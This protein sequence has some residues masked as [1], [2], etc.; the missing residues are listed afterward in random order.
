MEAAGVTIAICA[1]KMIKAAIAMLLMGIVADRLKVMDKRMIP[2]TALFKMLVVIIAIAMMTMLKTIA[3]RP[4][5]IGPSWATKKAL[6]PV[7]SAVKIL[8][9]GRIVTVMM[10]VSQ[11]TPLAAAW[12]KS[13]S[14]LC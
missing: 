11:P 5:S 13:I 3:D 14:G 2:T 1:Q 4:E 6:I 10:I 7:T 8:H 12:P 9:T